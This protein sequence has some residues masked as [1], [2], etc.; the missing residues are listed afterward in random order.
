MEF[1]TKV[2]YKN[3]FVYAGFYCIVENH[4]RVSSSILEVLVFLLRGRFDSLNLLRLFS[5]VQVENGREMYSQSQNLSTG[6]YPKL[7]S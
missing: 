3:R 4:C 6:Q 2:S 7:I 5:R 1:Q